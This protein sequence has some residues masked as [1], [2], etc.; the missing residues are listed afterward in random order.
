MSL[1]KTP[2][3]PAGKI[4]RQVT[5]DKARAAVC[6]CESVN[7]SISLGASINSKEL[8]MILLLNYTHTHAVCFPSWHPF[9]NQE[10]AVG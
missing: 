2:H 7:V 5:T 3:S 8:I 6:V 9:T 1:I 10:A 4:G